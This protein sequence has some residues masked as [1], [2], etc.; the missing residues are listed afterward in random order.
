MEEK[1][2]TPDG[3]PGY[4]RDSLVLQRGVRLLVPDTAPH[5]ARRFRRE[6]RLARR[7]QR[8][9]YDVVVAKL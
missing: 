6:S 8:L 5:A 7:L 1:Q 3:W 9:G 2:I 4:L